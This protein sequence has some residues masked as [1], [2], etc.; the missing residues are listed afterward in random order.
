MN[1]DNHYLL[2]DYVA[3][4]DATNPTQCPKSIIYPQQLLRQVY[5][6]HYRVIG[7]R[8]KTL[9]FGNF[10]TANDPQ[11]DTPVIKENYTYYRDE[12]NY[13]IDYITNDIAWMTKGGTWGPETKQV[14]KIFNDNEKKLGEV[15]LRRRNIVLELQGQ[16]VDLGLGSAIEDLFN[17]YWKEINLY[18]ESGSRAMYEAIE[19][20][21]NLEWLNYPTFVPTISVRQH[22]LKY[23]I[24]GVKP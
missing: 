17:T 22:L 19:S 23:F 14:I 10:G 5:A 16:S 11:F 21:T 18:Q 6:K 12:N 2:Y 4:E 1:K 15:R 9:Y 8:V 24:V 13:L 3:P 7:E 20:N